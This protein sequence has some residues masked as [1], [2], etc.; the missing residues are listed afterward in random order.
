MASFTVGAYPL[1]ATYQWYQGNTALSDGSGQWSGSQQPTLTDLNA[2]GSDTTNYYVVVSYGGNSVTSSV[3]SLTVETPPGFS[4]VP[5][6]AGLVYQQNFD[7]LPDPGTATVNNTTTLFPVAI[8]G[9]EYS[10]ANPF[11]FAAPLTV[12]G[13]VVGDYGATAGPAGGLN[14]PAMAGWYS[15]DLGNEQ[16]QATTGN[17]TTGLII[18]F[19]CTNANN[20]VNPN[21]PTNNRAL[22]MLS[23]PATAIQDAGGYPADGVFALRLRNL[24]GKTVTNFNLSYDSELWRNT[25][26]NNTLNNYF[27]VDPL[28]TNST[29]VNFWTGG[30]TNL[31]FTTNQP[32][33]KVGGSEYSTNQPIA[34][35]NVAFLNVPLTTPW[36]PGGILWLVWEETNSISGAQGLAIDN[37][38]FTT[39]TQPKLTITSGQPNLSYGL[40]TA[41]A[42]PSVTLSWPHLFTSAT[43]QSTTSLTPP[44]VWQPVT[45]TATNWQGIN[46]L[47]LPLGTSPRFYSL[48]N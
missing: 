37:L 33:Y 43:L 13:D 22:G 8:G 7:T 47:T 23:S 31:F 25:G 30:L 29:P 12:T 32:G 41:P 46:Y 17:T 6:T 39:G 18:S 20:T 36:T 48:A 34:I 4:A 26:I 42:V 11:D 16:I 44:I 14:L 40:P 15:S 10:V 35:T 19:G 45:T 2:Q 28:G 3:A 5:Y 27:Y 38:V 24:T 9:V 21:Y 1:N